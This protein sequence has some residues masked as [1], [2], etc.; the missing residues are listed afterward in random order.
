M[1]RGAISRDLKD[2]QKLIGRARL[3]SRVVLAGKARCERPC[4]P[5]EPGRARRGLWGDRRLEER[6]GIRS[7]GAFGWRAVVG[8]KPGKEGIKCVLG[9]RETSS[10]ASRWRLR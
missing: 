5:R 9:V 1:G 7:R 3:G 10:R 2:E 4:G 6:A 8:G